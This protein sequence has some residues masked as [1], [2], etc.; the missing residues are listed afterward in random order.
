METFRT[1]IAIELNQ[2][3]QDSLR[4]L[5][6]D[7]KR[8]VPPRSVR[9]VRPESIHLT[10]KFLG[11]VPS[12]RITSISQ[13]VEAA[14]QG[15]DVFT[16]ELVGLG[17]FPNPRRPRV[18]W[19]G[20]REPTSVLASL[21]KAVEQELAEI[22]FEPENRPFRPHLTL[23]RVQRKASQSEQKRLGE[24][25]ATSDLGPLGGMVVSAVNVMR[26]QLRPEGA[27]YTALAHVPLG[28]DGD[29]VP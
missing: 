13:A 16:F 7:L 15:F 19:V 4:H 8:K 24:L 2:E 3:L 14:C 10:L 5:Q 17:C 20:V 28:G 27:I 26:S 1:F 21:Q 23:G 18:L 9:W 6:D 11:D 25:V 12:S 22:G 29:A